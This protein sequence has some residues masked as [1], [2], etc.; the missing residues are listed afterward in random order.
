MLLP[1]TLDYSATHSRLMQTIIIVQDRA[2]NNLILVRRG[3]T[4]AQLLSLG[5]VCLPDLL[6]LLKLLLGATRGYRHAPSVEHAWRSSQSQA[7]AASF[8]LG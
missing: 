2:L 6:I 8:V 4:V 7:I 3:W 5:R 1:I